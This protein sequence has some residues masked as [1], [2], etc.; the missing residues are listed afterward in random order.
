MKKS[1]TITALVLSGASSAMAW[2]NIDDKL[3]GYDYSVAETINKSSAKI[4]GSNNRTYVKNIGWDGAT[5]NL[6]TDAHYELTFRIAANRTNSGTDTPIFNIYLAS[7]NSK[8]ILYGNYIDYG[9]TYLDG[10]AGVF[11]CDTNVSGLDRLNGQTG[12][13]ILHDILQDQAGYA[14]PTPATRVSSAERNNNVPLATGYH[15]YTI[16]IETF[17]DAGQPDRIKFKYAGANDQSGG[18]TQDFDLQNT[19]G[20]GKTDVLTVGAFIADEQAG[21]GDII[22]NNGLGYVGL[23][24]TFL[25]YERTIPTPDPEEPEPIPSTPSS[26]DIP[27]PSAFGL[28]A[29]VGAL[30]LVA[31]RR[32]R[33]KKA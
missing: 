22:L 17:A 25:A 24:Q 26:P 29:G 28:L 18:W 7:S 6:G 14:G 32:R 5:I 16:D 23:N 31:S 12:T 2:G 10:Y 4:L 8:S 13:C 33:V 15:T 21:Y 19:F 27:E 11:K 3:S 9:S 20:I 1:L 30:A